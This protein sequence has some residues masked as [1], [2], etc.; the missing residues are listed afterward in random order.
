MST[1]LEARLCQWTPTSI[2][3]YSHVKGTDT[4]SFIPFKYVPRNKTPTYS[5][6]VSDI[7]PHKQ[8]V[9]R[10]RLTV[11]GDRI[12]CSYDIITPVADLTIAK[13]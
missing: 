4:I 7:K 13:I 2:T 11:G 9:E 8:E 6:I 12:T 1:C 5:R 3:R 10:V